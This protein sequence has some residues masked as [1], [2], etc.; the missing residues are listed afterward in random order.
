[1][2]T[3]AARLLSRLCQTCGVLDPGPTSADDRLRALRGQAG[4]RAVDCQLLPRQGSL[5]SS[6]GPSPKLRS[7]ANLTRSPQ[8]QQFRNSS[9]GDSAHNRHAP[10][11]GPTRLSLEIMLARSATHRALHSRC[12]G[13]VLNQCVESASAGRSIRAR[14]RACGRS[15]PLYERP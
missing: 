8:P 10:G 7:P 3:A 6:L 2:W 9:S 15:R 12:F 11:N 14:V 1:M 13:L 4:G 5:S